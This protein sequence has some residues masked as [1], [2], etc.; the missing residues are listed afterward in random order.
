MKKGFKNWSEF[1]Q[2]IS[3]LFNGIIAFSLLPFAWAYLELDQ[4]FGTPL[5]GGVA[6]IIFNV[7][8]FVGIV[9]VLYFAHIQFVK[10]L[11]TLK[12]SQSVRSKLQLYYSVSVR[13]YITN[14]LAAILALGGTI[15]SQEILF[16]VVYVFI[17]FVFSLSRPRFDK[18]SEQLSLSDEE[19]ELLATSDELPE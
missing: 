10:S 15:I 11:K 16:A 12:K 18:V 2:R 9:V 7:V 14:E 3:L 17:L 1:Y 5:L 6:L 13:K 4:G 8:I 19:K